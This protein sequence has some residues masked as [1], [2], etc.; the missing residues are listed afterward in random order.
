MEKLMVKLFS[1]VMERVKQ[2]LQLK[3]KRFLLLM[4]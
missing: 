2:N 1:R 4:G 3:A